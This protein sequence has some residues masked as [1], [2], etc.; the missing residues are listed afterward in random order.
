[1]GKM[2]LLLKK[3]SVYVIY[4]KQFWH[5]NIFHQEAS[6]HSTELSVHLSVE[7]EPQSIG[8]Q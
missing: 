8:L 1:M 3:V 7:G 4:L 2:E 5:T 6:L